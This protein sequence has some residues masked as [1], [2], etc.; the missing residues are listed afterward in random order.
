M[1]WTVPRCSVGTFGNGLGIRT[2]IRYRH[3]NAR[4]AY[5]HAGDGNTAMSDLDRLGGMEGLHKIVRDFVHQ[6]RDDMII[7]F[8]FEGREIAKIVQRETEFAAMHL[9][10]KSQERYS[11]RPMGVVHQ[12]LKIGKGHFRRRLAILR[13]TLLRHEVPH[14]IV[15]RWLQ[16]DQRL[17]ALITDGTDCLPDPH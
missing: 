3:N 17:E 12:P 5:A 4:T 11:G 9:G 16:H 2:P 1:R 10:D 8:F 15:E 14:D 13:A 6:E 7:G